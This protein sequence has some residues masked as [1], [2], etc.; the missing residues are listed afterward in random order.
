MSSRSAAGHRASSIQVT[1][2]ASGPRQLQPVSLKGQL[3]WQPRPRGS[4]AG[5]L[6]TQ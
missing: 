1:Y 2:R 6:S 3:S 5:Y 4:N